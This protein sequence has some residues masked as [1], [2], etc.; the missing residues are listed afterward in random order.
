M[1]RFKLDKQGVEKIR[2]L[3]QHQVAKAQ[4]EFARESYDY[5]LNF[6]YHKDGGGV[7]W[8]GGGWALYY[9]SN[10]NVGINQVDISVTPAVRIAERFNY[11][12]NVDYEKAKWVTDNAEFGDTITVTNS[13]RYGPIL[14]DGGFFDEVGEFDHEFCIPNRVMEQCLDYLEQNAE[15][16]VE[17]VAKECPEI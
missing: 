9:L 5:F 12:G 8:G 2:S 7:E 4:K 3:L 11:R 17:Q 13:V 16:I 1:G 14:N 10:W 15:L 6:G